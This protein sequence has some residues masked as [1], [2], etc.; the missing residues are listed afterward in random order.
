MYDLWKGERY[1][2]GRLDT[3]DREKRD[4]SFEQ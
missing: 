2:F 1:G 4:V 3:K